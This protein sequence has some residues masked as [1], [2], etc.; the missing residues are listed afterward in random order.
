DRL[1]AAEPSQLV[2]TWRRFRRHRLALIGLCILGT[3]GALC[4]LAP[5][6]AP[7]DPS[8]QQLY[9]TFEGA[10]GEHWL[11]TDSL[12][13]DMLTRLM[14]AG[15]ISLVIGIVC[16]AIVVVVG[17]LV[18]SLAGYFGGWVDTV[19]MR[20]VDLGLSVPTFPLLIALSQMLS[21][22]LPS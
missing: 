11:G 21:S 5:W 22:I 19:L 4:L 18:G 8:S 10:T 13:R 12:G 7:Y 17:S 15:R 1:A 14:Y 2:V 9:R 3:I 20:I 6:I 16:T